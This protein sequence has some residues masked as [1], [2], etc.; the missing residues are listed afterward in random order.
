[1]ASEKIN[2][3]Y[4]SITY[5]WNLII[6]MKLHLWQ[7][8][9][10]ISKGLIEVKAII[11]SPRQNRIKLSYFFSEN[12]YQQHVDTANFNPFVIATIFFAMRQGI[13]MHVHGQI[14]P[15]LLKNLAEF[16]AA[17]M[18]WQPEQYTQ[19]EIIAET[20]REFPKAGTNKALLFQVALI[21]TSP[22]YVIKKYSR[23]E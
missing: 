14:S 18:S 6:I 17:W 9:Y 23:I 16:Q 7:E 3:I 10:T 21:V 19:I 11:E 15:S 2:K 5:Q 20:E 22:Y 12:V 1:M 13:D 8:D 4:L